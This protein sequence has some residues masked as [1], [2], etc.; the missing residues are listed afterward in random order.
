MNNNQTFKEKFKDDQ[1]LE[2]TL[3]EKWGYCLINTTFEVK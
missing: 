3:A 1:E 2:S